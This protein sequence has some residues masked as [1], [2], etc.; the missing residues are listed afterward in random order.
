MT[1]KIPHNISSAARAESALLTYRKATQCDFEDSLVDLLTDLMHWAR[2]S[3]FDF[4]LALDRA[5]MNYDA[6]A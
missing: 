2:F 6:E 1:M 5:R 3:R 4:D